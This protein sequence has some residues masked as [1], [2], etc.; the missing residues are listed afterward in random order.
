MS[1]LNIRKLKYLLLPFTRWT[2][3]KINKSTEDYGKRDQLKI[4]TSFAL[5]II[6][7]ICLAIISLLGIIVGF[8]ISIFLVLF[9]VI[10]VVLFLISCVIILIGF[11]LSVPWLIIFCP[12]LCCYCVIGT[13]G[14][15]ASAA[16]DGH[17]S[18]K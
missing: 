18:E 4:A 9:L 5:D 7:Y 11:V 13:I 2:V 16:L 15:I 1:S 14:I 3:K 6:V 12:C 8:F 10:F 17:L